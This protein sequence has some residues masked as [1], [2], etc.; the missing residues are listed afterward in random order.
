ML[1][2]VS[3]ITNAI[4]ALNYKGTW[5]ASTNTPTIV[6][7][8][9]VKGDYYVVSVAGTTNINGISNWGIGDWIVFNGSTWQRVEGGADLN[10]VNVSFTGTASGPTYETNN[11][12]AGLT[13]SDNDI[14]ADGTDANIDIDLIPKGTGEVN[15][16]KVDID[17][18]AIDGTTIG[19]SV[20]ST[21]S[22]TQLDVDNVRIDGNT[23]S[24]TNTNGDLLLIP[25]GNGK[26]GVNTALPGEAL[27]VVGNI[28][29]SNTNSL[30]FRNATGTAN[31]SFSYSNTNSFVGLGP[32]GEF[33]QTTANFSIFRHSTGASI[34]IN[35]GS[36]IQLSTGGVSRLLITSS[37]ITAGNG[38]TAASPNNSL[39]QG[40]G[41]SGTDITGATLT[42]QGGRGTGSASGGPIVFSTSAA[43][44]SGTTLNAA[45][46]RVRV[47]PTGQVRFQPLAADPANAEA[48]D[49]Y[50][51]S[52]DNK[53]KCYN[54]TTWN[55]LF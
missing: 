16:P 4:G 33:M 50:Y 53:L 42:I 17:S 21:G 44:S 45:S 29:I 26:V 27:D 12:T 11:A 49:V 48:G 9:G 36:Q 55:D 30:L 32:G 28:R 39:I 35:S 31:L 19:A 23:V 34:L 51:N 24:S 10:G 46:E 18:G 41:G 38:E 8:V 37:A 54:G 2:S 3:S 25:N 47:K 13:I 7:S 43:G 15:L 20:A 14:T 1:K 52:V 6:S 5:D 22:F 40:T